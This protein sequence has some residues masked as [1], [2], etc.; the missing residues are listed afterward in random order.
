MER[1]NFFSLTIDKT[2]S[3]VE[4]ETDSD[5]IEYEIYMDNEY[6][7]EKFCNILVA[8]ERALIIFQ[9]KINEELEQISGLHKQDEK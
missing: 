9:E 8:K 5:K 7:E 1:E 6:Q 3:I 4:S 2:V